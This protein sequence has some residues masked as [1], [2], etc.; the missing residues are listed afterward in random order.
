MGFVGGFNLFG[1][2]LQNPLLLSDPLG[3]AP[4]RN[5]SGR[6]IPYKP[7]HDENT[8]SECQPGTWCN[9]DGL[10]SPEGSDKQCAI[11]IP[12]NCVAWATD[13]GE[14]HG[15]C[16]APRVR[17]PVVMTPQMFDQAEFANWP[18]PYGGDSRWPYEDWDPEE[19]CGCEP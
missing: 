9:V 7:E 1:Y 14:L 5:G 13:E 19:K 6:A 3:L 18:N 15:F 4:F 11:K 16:I 17:F 2:A 10:F 12:D 8:V